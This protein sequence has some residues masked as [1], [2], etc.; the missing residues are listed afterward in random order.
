MYQDEF[1][2]SNNKIEQG[3]EENATFLSLIKIPVA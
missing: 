2:S 3:Y 1:Q